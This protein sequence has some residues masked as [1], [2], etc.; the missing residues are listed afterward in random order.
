MK[1]FFFVAAKEK[2][3]INNGAQEMPSQYNKVSIAEFPP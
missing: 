3:Y 2:Q 1:L